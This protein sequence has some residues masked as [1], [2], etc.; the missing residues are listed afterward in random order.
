MRCM[1]VKTVRFSELVKKAGQPEGHLVL[2]DPKRD[3]TLQAAIKA[4]RVLTIAQA[5]VGAK[6]D[7]GQIGFEAGAN[8]Q[9]LIFPKSL[10]AFAGRQVIGITYDLITEA[11]LPASQRAA[12]PRPPKKAPAPKEKFLHQE[13]EDEVKEPAKKKER[14]P[15][16]KRKI[17]PFSAA[18]KTPK[19]LQTD[20]ADDETVEDLKKEIRRA[21]DLLEDGKAVAAFN[22]LKRA[23]GD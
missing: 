8:R 20:E 14:S 23:V 6:K 18:K 12:T 15:P 21:M 1:S 11:D 2:I 22:L 17:I 9:F 16:R 10:K 4:G 7:R 13:E 5:T 19:D 3:K